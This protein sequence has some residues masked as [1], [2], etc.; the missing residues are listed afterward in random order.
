MFF[1]KII[2]VIFFF[3]FLFN[4]F[5][6]PQSANVDSLKIN[7]PNKV[8]F[9]KRVYFSVFATSIDGNSLLGNAFFYEVLDGNGTQ[10][11]E[12]Y[13]YRRECDLRQYESS[14][15]SDCYFLFGASNVGYGYI[16]ITS[17]Y[18][19]VNSTY[20]LRVYAGDKNASTT[21]FVDRW[22]LKP[23][24]FDFMIFIKDNLFYILFLFFGIAGIILALKIFF[25]ITR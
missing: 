14:M 5:A 20:T 2:L 12:S 22:E 25:W 15:P 16:D 19:D 1:K 7:I 11:I 17:A 24:G 18:Y 10:L 4:V 6:I 9:E 13:F 21:F 3:F 23:L 8:F